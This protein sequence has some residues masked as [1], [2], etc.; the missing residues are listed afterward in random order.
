M[1]PP[2]AAPFIRK[3]TTHEPSWMS[4]HK[5]NPIVLP[6]GV[7]CEWPGQRDHAYR[8]W[9]SRFAEEPEPQTRMEETMKLYEFA[10][11]RSLRVRW[12]LQE[13]GVEFEAVTVNM[14]AGDH[15]RP[16]FLQINPA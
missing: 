15:R 7:T 1:R 9:W 6:L 5:H 10:P 12:T 11:T 13:L 4:D 2:A 14:I 8:H 16:E 3:A